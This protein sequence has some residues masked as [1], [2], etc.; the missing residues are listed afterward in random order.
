MVAPIVTILVIIK[1]QLTLPYK[2][3]TLMAVGSKDFL[4]LLYR[5][6]KGK[7]ETWKPVLL[8]RRL[9]LKNKTN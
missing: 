8:P 2:K 3:Q 5:V 7:L 1:E 6:L 4:L 9:D